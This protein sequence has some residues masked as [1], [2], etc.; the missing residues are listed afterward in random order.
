MGFKLNLRC[1]NPER[2]LSVLV[3]W[4]FSNSGR[5]LALPMTAAAVLGT[6]ALYGHQLGAQQ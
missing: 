2:S 1:K 6:S 3:S 4:L 5:G